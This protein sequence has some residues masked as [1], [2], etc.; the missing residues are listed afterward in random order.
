MNYQSATWRIRVAHGQYVE[1]SVKAND[2]DRQESSPND[3][4]RAA[5]IMKEIGRSLDRITT[6]WAKVEATK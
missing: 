3:I 1:L 2:S 5:S 6:R 4:L